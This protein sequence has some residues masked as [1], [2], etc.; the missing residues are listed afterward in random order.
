MTVTSDAVDEI[1]VP[2]C[3]ADGVVLLVCE[4]LC[5]VDDVVSCVRGETV[6]R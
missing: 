5:I 1:R 3:I 2:R 4:E 6:H